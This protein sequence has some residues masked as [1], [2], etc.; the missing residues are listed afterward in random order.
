MLD[1][2]FI[3]LFGVLIAFYLV[4]FNFPESWKNYI[5]GSLFIAM[6]LALLMTGWQST[7]SSLGNYVTVTDAVTGDFNVTFE[8]ATLQA[9]I[10]LI[11]SN[12]FDWNLFFMSTFLFFGGAAIALHKGPKEEEE[13]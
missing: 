7:N 9:N 2:T 12:A 11:D 3:L 8:P 1:I 13:Y 5:V 10:A 4:G 6:A